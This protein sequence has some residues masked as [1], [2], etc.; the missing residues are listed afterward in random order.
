[1]GSEMCIRDRLKAQ[2]QE[3]VWLPNLKASSEEEAET[4]EESEEVQ[5]LKAELERAQVVQEK[6]KMTTIKVRKECDKSRD[7]NVA[8][9]KALERETK[10]VPKEEWGRDKF[11]GALWDNNS[12]L[13]L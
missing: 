13:K 6:F 1:M 2:T 10:R 9:A 5:A 12:E 4:P 8:T 7:V 11:R 3:L